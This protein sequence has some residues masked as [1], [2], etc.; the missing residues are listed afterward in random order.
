MNNLTALARALARTAPG[1]LLLRAI[2]LATGVAAFGIA[3]PGSLL[4]GPMMMAGAVLAAIAAI[5]PGGPFVSMVQLGTV[6]LWLLGTAMDGGGRSTTALISVACALYLQ[7]SACALA[8]AVPLDAVVLPAVLLRWF[9][10]TAGVMLITGVLGV[11]VVTLSEGAKPSPL[12]VFPLLGVVG[13]ILAAGIL[14]YLA[15]RSPRR[16]AS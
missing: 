3:L 6:V 13:A 1:P 11:V 10:R 15:L 8:A 7:H 2:V 9:T 12:L 4:T 5:A 16:G 14:A